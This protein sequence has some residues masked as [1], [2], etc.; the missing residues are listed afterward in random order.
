[1]QVDMH[2]FLPGDLAVGDE[3]VDSLA[4]QA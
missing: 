4:R 3:E 2:N 1:V